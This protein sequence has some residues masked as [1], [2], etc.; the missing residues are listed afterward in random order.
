VFNSLKNFVTKHIKKAIY[1]I[2]CIYLRMF[3]NIDLQRWIPLLVAG[4][5]LLL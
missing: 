3:L 2:L 5:A 4:T 1:F